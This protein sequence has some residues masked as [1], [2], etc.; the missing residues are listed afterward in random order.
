MRENRFDQRL[1]FGSGHT[2]G[3][4]GSYRIAKLPRPQFHIVEVGNRLAQLVG[5][6]GKHRLE[7]AEGYA[8]I[9]GIFGRDGL[10]GQ[11]IADKYRDTPPLRSI[12][13]VALA[14]F[15]LREEVEDL[16]VDILLAGRFQFGADVPRHA[17]DVVLQ[18]V[19]ILENALVDALEHIVVRSVGHD[20]ECIVDQAVAERTDIGHLAFEGKVTGDLNQLSVHLTSL[21]PVRNGI[22][23][24]G[25]RRRG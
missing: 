5:Q 11:C 25:S 13:P 10:V 24:R 4:I 14:R 21:Q 22:P 18:Q 16:A 6:V 15:T 17:V 23:A 7:T 2:A 9:S 19:H 3:R 20:K 12:R 1:Y 8:G